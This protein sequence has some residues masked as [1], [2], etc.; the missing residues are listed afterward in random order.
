MKRRNPMRHRPNGVGA[1]HMYLGELLKK[2]K[3]DGKS[4]SERTAAFT[5]AQK[6]AAEMAKKVKAEGSKTKFG[7]KAVAAAKTRN[8]AVQ[9]KK[10]KRRVR[11]GAQTLAGPKGGKKHVGAML[12]A[13]YKALPAYQRLKV[14]TQ[15][16]IP[17]KYKRVGGKLVQAS[18]PVVLPRAPRK[19][20]AVAAIRPSAT[21]PPAIASTSPSGRKATSRKAATGRK[22]TGKKATAQKYSGIKIG[23]KGRNMYFLSGKMVSQAAYKAARPGSSSRPSQMMDNPRRRKGARKAHRKMGMMRRLR[24]TG[25]GVL[26]AEK[27]FFGN[28]VSVPGIVSVVGVGIA[29]GVVAPMVADYLA[30]MFPTRVDLPVV[31]NVGASNLAFTA[32]GLVAG[33]ALVGLG[34]TVAKG[35]QGLLNKMAMLAVGGGALIDMVGIVMNAVGGAEASEMGAIDNDGTI[36]GAIDNDGTIYGAIDDNGNVYGDVVSYGGLMEDGDNVSYGTVVGSEYADAMPGD[37]E[38]SG[39]DFN[40]TEGQALVEGPL[41]WLKRFGKSPVRATNIRGKKSRHAGREGHRW[42]WMI[43]LVGMD[44]AQQIA[45]LPPEK[46]VE[47][48]A[49]LRKAALESLANSMNAQAMQTTAQVAPQNLLPASEQM[50]L[51]LTGAAGTANGAYGAHMYAG[52]GY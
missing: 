27:S 6:K 29:H 42:G 31:G 34:A 21:R 41:S 22:A 47:V 52:G 23:A 5:K 10:M 20:K 3:L 48:I 17:G 11:R 44:K 9:A 15:R 49:R 38:D 43:K 13:E 7:A 40:V 4:Q 36:Y 25:E 37:A 28:L 24:N 45:A 19:P 1:Y 46:R 50:G 12:K 26:A 16:I 14:R 51:D 30:Q 18:A 32:T 2:A 33:G 8:A 35:Q 39:A